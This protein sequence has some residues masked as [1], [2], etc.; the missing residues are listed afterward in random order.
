MSEVETDPVL[1]MVSVNWMLVKQHRTLSPGEFKFNGQPNILE[2][3]LDHVFLILTKRTSVP[4]VGELEGRVPKMLSRLLAEFLT[5]TELQNFHAGGLLRYCIKHQHWSIF[6][7]VSMTLE[8]NT[9]RGHRV[10]VLRHR[11][12]TFQEFSQRYGD[13]AP[14]PRHT[15]TRSPTT[16]HQESSEQYLRPSTGV[17]RLLV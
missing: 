15:S 3:Q 10:Q 9:N 13:T 7:T 1:T 11:S 6:E 17:Q 8:I 14:H 4:L 2:T 16:G 5:P 12:F